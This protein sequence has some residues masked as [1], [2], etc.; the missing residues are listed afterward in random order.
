MDLLILDFLNSDWL[1]KYLKTPI[2]DILYN[3]DWF[4]KQLALW[5]LRL[6]EELTD[7]QIEKLIVLRTELRHSY[8]Q[9]LIKELDIESI[10]AKINLELKQTPLIKQL[11]NKEGYKAIYIPNSYDYYWLRYN[12]LSS[13]TELLTVVNIERLRI[14]ENPDCKFVFYD[15]SRNSTKRHCQSSCSNLMKVRRFREKT[16]KK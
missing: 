4:K 6:D 7:E 2:K 11:I 8:N 9:L 3:R 12:I 14:C 16:T 15:S 5:S 13:F 1:N 10:I